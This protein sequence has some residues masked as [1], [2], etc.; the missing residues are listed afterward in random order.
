[1]HGYFYAR[2]KEYAMYFQDNF[3]VNS[4]L[5]VNMG[6][7]WE[8]WPAFTE[9]NNMLTSFDPK[10]K[11][12]VLGSDLQ[13]MYKL[14]T[15]IPA[16]VDRYTSLGAKFITYDQAGLPRTMM[17]STKKDFGPRL[18]F[19]Y[20]AGDGRKQFVIRSGFRVAYFHIPTR[21]WVARMRSNAP[22][23]ARFRTSVTDATLTPDGIANYGMR[24]V[25]TIIAGLNSSN[26]VTLN[27]ASGLNR[28]SAVVSYFAQNQPDARVADWNFTVEKEVMSNTVVRAGWVG[29]RSSNLEQFYQYNSAPSDYIWFTTT[30]QPLPTGEFAAV[31]RNNFDKNVYGGI[32]EYR[33]T[34]YGNFSG[35]QFEIERR[36]SKGFAYQL[37]YVVGNNMAA[38]GQ[39]FSGTSIVPESNL[40]LPGAVPT[41]Y[42]A[43]NKLLNYQ[44]DTSVPKH[45]VNWNWI[46]DLPF[47]KG[48]H[49]GGNA[50]GLVNALI[51]GWQIAG[52]GTLRSTYIA[53][54]T[55]NWPTG[56]PVEQYG[57]K[58]PIQDCTAG[59][60]YPGYLWTNGYIPA[61]RINSVDANGKP[62]G[63]MGVPA[64]YKPAVAPLIPWGST[65]LPP[66][67]P[68]NTDVASFWD[69]NNVWIPLSNGTVQRTTYND[70]LHPYRLQYIP[71]TLQWNQDAS[72]FKAIPIKE[73][74]MVRFNIDFFNVFNHPGNPSAVAATGILS[75]RSSGM[76]PR[77]IQLTGRMTW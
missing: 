40:F 15:T 72:I 31:A 50:R 26:A 13:T 27:T 23:T 37:F 53:L 42:D 74:W 30:R 9:K 56:N 62:N 17:T 73:G 33:M 55:N 8:Y 35:A 6:L 68:A 7:R 19:A 1:V 59:T 32:E 66:N 44:R 61:N 2:G 45:R 57:Y 20:K 11:S 63:I 21:P 3:K 69:T 22:L 29:N 77:V 34:G 51:G 70:N 75:T 4:R 60:C 41:D 67:A 38:G 5:T 36:Y 58:Y 14:G 71:S 16:I 10:T 49:W 65:A 18:G 46:V 76:N 52:I 39:S 28:G 12:I 43:R 24:S 54:P 25:P 64:N 47:G 48:K